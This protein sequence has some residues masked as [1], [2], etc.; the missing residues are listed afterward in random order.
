MPSAEGSSSGASSPSEPRPDHA[1]ALVATAATA[2]AAAGTDAP[3]NA[4]TSVVRWLSDSFAPSRE[5]HQRKKLLENLAVSTM[6]TRCT[7]EQRERVAAL[8]T[9]LEFKRGEILQL[10]GEPQERAL[11][12]VDGA[13]VRQ[14]V[15]DGDQVHVVAPQGVKGSGAT[16]GMLH[17]LKRDRSFATLKCTSDGHAFQIKSEDLARALR[18]DR[19]LALGVIASLSYE[20]RAQTAVY[21]KQTPLFLQR[22]KDISSEQL[23]LFAVTCAAAV[24]SFYRS[25]MNAMINAAITGQPRAALFPNMHIQL[26]VRVLYING[27]KGLRYLMDHKIDLDSLAYPQL[28]GATLATVPGVVMSPVSSVLEASNAGHRNPEP[29]S[30]RWTRGFA[31]R[32][33]RE[34]IFGVG[35]N[36]LSD[37]YEERLTGVIQNQT[38]RNMGGSFVAGLVAGYLSHVPHSLSALKLLSPNKS[39][40]ELFHSYSDVWERRVPAHVGGGALRPYLVGS[41]ACLMP[42]GVLTRSAQ[43]AGSFIIINSAINALRMFRLDVRFERQESS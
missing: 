37:F 31:P 9:P 41:L 12:M 24:E 25:G 21:A 2:A 6:F 29:M 20:V 5:S 43:L 15:E 7:P 17:V 8:F 10:Q 14:R 23:P 19:E 40:R 35:M 1:A 32:C 42:K 3:A 16:V 26:P 11:I 13:Y 4:L 18:E 34:V 38:M 22:G 30:R 27:F 28:A 39:Y 33:L 36:Q